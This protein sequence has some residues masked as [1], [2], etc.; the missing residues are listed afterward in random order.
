MSFVSADL[1]PGARRTTYDVPG[2]P[3]AGVELLPG[4]EPYGTVLLVPGFSGSKEDFGPL[5]PELAAGGWRVVALD[6]RGQHES[7]GPD[8]PA[9]YTVEALASDVLAVADGLGT[10]L[11]LL[12]HSF[13]GLVTRAAVLRRPDAFRS[14]VLLGSGPQ[15]L[16]GPR[17]DVLPFLPGVIESGGMAAVADASEAMSPTDN[18]GQPV[19]DAVKAF[20]R[21]RW[22]TSSPVGLIAMGDA[23]CTE[24]DRVDALRATGV[25]VLVA[26]G[27]L[28]DAWLPPVQADMA[29][30]LGAAYEVVPGAAHSPNAEQPEATAKALLAFLDQLT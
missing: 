12:G 8:D 15:A 14:L 28:D 26:H 18:L 27:A 23:L 13:G 11:H 10:P 9:A 17:V 30:R 20:L 24:P 4:G 22:T 16:T 6:Q 1:P 3:L 7:P 19:P 25:P 21:I 29:K 5:L 2:G